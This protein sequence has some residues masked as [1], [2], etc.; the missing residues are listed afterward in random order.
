MLNAFSVHPASP[1]ANSSFT[2]HLFSLPILH[3]FS[4][5]LSSLTFCTAVVNLTGPLF[6]CVFFLLALIFSFYFSNLILVI[7]LIYYLL[8]WFDLS[9]ALAA[10]SVEFSFAPGAFSPIA[11]R[12]YLSI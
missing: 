2:F 9:A 10:F 3:S 8:R 11:G 1:L 5:L 12:F 4:L 6:L 7:V